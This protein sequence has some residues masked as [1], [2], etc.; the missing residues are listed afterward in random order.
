MSLHIVFI[1][2][3]S[4][5]IGVGNIRPYMSILL[6]PLSFLWLKGSNGSMALAILR[7]GSFNIK[8]GS[9]CMKVR[10]RLHVLPT[11]STAA[12]QGALETW[13]AARKSR[14]MMDLFQDATDYL[15]WNNA[16]RSDMLAAYADIM[17]NLFKLVHPDPLCT[18]INIMV[19]IMLNITL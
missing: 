3:T 5:I 7:R 6:C 2:Y 13:M 12:I 18:M 11:A 16:P 19:Y 1:P 9:A 17:G 15:T 14:D 8:D 10:P 4:R